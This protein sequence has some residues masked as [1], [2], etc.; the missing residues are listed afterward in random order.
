MS[1]QKQILRD[2]RPKAGKLKLKRSNKA[3]LLNA[4]YYKYFPFNLGINGNIVSINNIN[5][6]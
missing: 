4:L 6:I 3:I 2:L 5:P 1:T